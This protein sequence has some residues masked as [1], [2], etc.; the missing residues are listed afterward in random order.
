MRTA[1]VTRLAAVPL[2]RVTPMTHMM[3]DNWK[4]GENRVSVNVEWMFS[5]KS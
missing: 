5:L 2:C 3:R 4:T 1:T